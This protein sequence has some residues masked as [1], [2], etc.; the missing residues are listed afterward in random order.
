MTRIGQ[1]SCASPCFCLLPDRTPQAATAAFRDRLQLAISCIT[2]SVFQLEGYR[3]VDRVLAATLN[4][5][6]PV[7]LRVST[8]LLCGIR[9]HYRV[10]R[11]DAQLW[12]AVVAAYFF[13]LMDQAETEILAYHW[14]PEGR[15][16]VTQPHLHLGPGLG[17]LT[18]ISAR[19]HLPTGPIA[20][21][22]FIGLCIVEFGASPR[23]AD[24]ETV[25]RQ[26]RNDQENY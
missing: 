16:P 10:L 6:D 1:R 26:T 23:R 13:E 22:D 20:I 4:R 2:T 14:H 5:G 17:Q 19:A 25:L 18:R 11:T 21:E 7:P 3:Q 24:W 9:L 15:S 8:G 12:K